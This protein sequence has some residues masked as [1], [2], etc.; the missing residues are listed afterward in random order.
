MMKSK[1]ALAVLLTSVALAPASARPKTH[2]KAASTAKAKSKPKAKAATA[3][4]A[5][6]SR[7]LTGREAK[8]QQARTSYAGAITSAVRA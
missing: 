6:M 1:I 3:K 4:K 2:H 8:R 5:R 7:F